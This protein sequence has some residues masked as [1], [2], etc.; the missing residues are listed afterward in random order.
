MKYFLK[1]LILTFCLNLPFSSFSQNDSLFKQLMSTSD[2]M[3][4]VVLVL[5]VIFAGIILFLILLDKRIKKLE[6]QS[7]G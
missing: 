5:L 2:K 3:F 4:V 1:I 7:N 6:N